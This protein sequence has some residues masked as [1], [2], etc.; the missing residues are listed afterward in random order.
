MSLKGSL[1][2]SRTFNSV[3]LFYK[4]EHSIFIGRD[5]NFF[6]DT[7]RCFFYKSVISIVEVTIHTITLN[8]LK[9]FFPFPKKHKI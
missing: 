7:L 1:K 9:P 2:S 6:F 5:N 4:L 8:S 3:S